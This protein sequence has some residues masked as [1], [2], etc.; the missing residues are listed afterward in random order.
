[1]S[2]RSDNRGQPPS[3]RPDPGRRRTRHVWITLAALAIVLAYPTAAAPTK[4]VRRI[5]ILNEANAT[6]PGI[7]II[8][9][10]IQAGLNDSPYHL[11]L[12]SEYMDTSLFPD[13]AVQ[14]EFRDSYIRKYQNLKLDVIITVGPSPL[15]FMQEVHQKSFPGVPIV[16]C[17]PTLG[18][19][20]TPILDSDFTGVENDMAPA[21]TVGIALRL[22][23]G[24]R[25]VVVVGG[26]AAH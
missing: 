8:N 4:E 22:L 13:Q 23:P 11:Q 7:S 24:T 17:L 16:F 10:G 15:K 1:M 5:L 21:E 6:Y 12:Y 26:V 9:Q 25:N 3:G 14:Q 20:G 19:P 2:H 18:V